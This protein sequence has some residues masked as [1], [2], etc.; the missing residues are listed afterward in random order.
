VQY[1]GNWSISNYDEKFDDDDFLEICKFKWAFNIKPDIVF[2]IDRNT[3]ICIEAKLGSGEGSYPT[4][5]VE[6]NIFKDRGLKDKHVK[7][8][9]L[10]EY[11]M[12]N[13]LGLK[14]DL[15]FLGL[16]KVERENFRFMHWKEA[17]DLLDLADLPCFAIEMV[18]RISK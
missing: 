9:D 1:P 17:F 4:S 2:H 7:Q 5:K 18:K 10:Q 14:T 15:I 12:K 13:L 8:M 11:M 3:A 6:N 16:K